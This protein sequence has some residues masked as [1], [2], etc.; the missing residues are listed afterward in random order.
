MQYQIPSP[1]SF[2][3]TDQRDSRRSSHSATPPVDVDRSA[4]RPFGRAARPPHSGFTSLGLF[5][6]YAPPPPLHLVTASLGRTRIVP[7]PRPPAPV[8]GPE[9]RWPTAPH[10]PPP[11]RGCSPHLAFLWRLFIFKTNENHVFSGEIFRAYPRV[12]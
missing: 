6:T 8:H 9:A 4:V 11:A 2:S 5:V 10:H 3:S 1:V 7:P 12:L